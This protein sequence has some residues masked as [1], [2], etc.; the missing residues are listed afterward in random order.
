NYNGVTLGYKG[1]LD[2]DVW[3]NYPGNV[4]GPGALTFT[5]RVTNLGPDVLHRLTSVNFTG[6]QTDVDYDNIVMPG[7]GPSSINRSGNGKIVG[8]NFD[9]A[10]NLSG[11]ALTS[12]LIIHTNATQFTQTTDSVIDGLPTDVPSFGPTPIP[13]PVAIGA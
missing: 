4:Y 2:S 11:G 9:L 7:T 6:W 10:G 1:S 12:L 13:E 8:W 5:Y 3:T